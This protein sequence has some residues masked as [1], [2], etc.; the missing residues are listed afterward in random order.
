MHITDDLNDNY[1]GSGLW[2]NRAIRKYGR[3]SFKKE[4]LHICDSKEEMHNLEKLLVETY[5]E[6][7]LSYN[8]MKGGKGGW[9][10]LNEEFA[11]GK[12]I[13]VNPHW[14]DNQNH[15]MHNPLAV[16]KRNET[17]YEKYGDDYYNNISQ[18]GISAMQAKYGVCN[19]MDSSL[20]RN[21]HLKS[22]PEDHQKG[23]SNSQYGKKFKFINNGSVNKKV[24]L[25]E[26]DSY[27][28]NGFSVGRIPKP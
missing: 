7:P 25:S 12:R 14:I 26:L 15:P 19:A 16:Q 2:L 21:N 22:L 1:L 4:I 5:K 13:R 23:K 27:L 3:D 17:L 10:W 24:E 8:I 28:Q 11:Q 20:V 9:D 6:N 18:K